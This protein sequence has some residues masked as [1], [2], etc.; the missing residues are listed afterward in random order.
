MP[1]LGQAGDQDARVPLDV[2]RSQR[3]LWPGLPRPSSLGLRFSALAAAHIDLLTDCPSP[4]PFLPGALHP[5]AV[6]LR[7]YGQRLLQA[8]GR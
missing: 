6:N 7:S 4:E 2:Y 3:G 1:W 8:C 5:A